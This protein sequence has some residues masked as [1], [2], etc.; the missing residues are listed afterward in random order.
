MLR[1]A[2]TE[3]DGLTRDLDAPVKQTLL[4]LLTSHRRAC[5]L[6]SSLFSGTP[7]SVGDWERY[8]NLEK[9]VLIF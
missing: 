8:Q 4:N 6:A 1:E 2:H 7:S 9:R 3:G 5:G